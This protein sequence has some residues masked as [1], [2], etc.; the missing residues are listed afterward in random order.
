MEDRYMYNELIDFEKLSQ[1]SEKETGF[2][3]PLEP[4]AVKF[5]PTNT[6][7]VSDKLRKKKLWCLNDMQLITEYYRLKKDL[8]DN[9]EKS[10]RVFF[11]TG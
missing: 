7:R 10:Y 8:L 3:L 4:L 11:K 2:R 9:L 1:L 6:K 5:Y